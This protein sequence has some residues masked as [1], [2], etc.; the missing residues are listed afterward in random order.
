MSLLR[1]V[2]VGDDDVTVRLRDWLAFIDSRESLG[3]EGNSLFPKRLRL[4]SPVPSL[5]SAFVVRLGRPEWP[6]EQP[7]AVRS[8]AWVWVLL[9]SFFCCA[10]SGQ[11]APFLST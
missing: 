2:L 10:P 3:V 4:F 8:P 7:S 9:P 1:H 11:D 6:V 5:P